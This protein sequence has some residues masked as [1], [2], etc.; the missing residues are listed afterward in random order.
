MSEA[1]SHYKLLIAKADA[2]GTGGLDHLAVGRDD[3]EAANRLGHGC[4]NS[5]GR[6]Q[7]DLAAQLNGTAFCTASVWINLFYSSRGLLNSF[8][9]QVIRIS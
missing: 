4:S 9:R 7:G 5:V 3:T 8:V 2:R 1:A 6:A